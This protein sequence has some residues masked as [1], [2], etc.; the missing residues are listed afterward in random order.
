[1]TRSR[2]IR[3]LS[4]RYQAKGRVVSC[5]PVRFA[6]AADRDFDYS[7]LIPDL[8]FNRPPAGL[9]LLFI[10]AVMHYEGCATVTLS[11]PA[12]RMPASTIR[13]QDCNTLQAD[14][15][16]KR[17]REEVRSRTEAE[18]LRVRVTRTVVD[19]LRL[20]EELWLNRCAV[21]VSD[22]VDRVPT[23][24]QLSELREPPLVVEPRRVPQLSRVQVIIPHPFQGLPPHWCSR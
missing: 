4:E 7:T 2:A 22:L 8:P 15:T 24:P 14:I 17:Y 3:G 21:K 16:R 9:C 5:C 13:P 6:C 1:M 18:A 20:P 11:I 23:I 12:S 19:S 10:R